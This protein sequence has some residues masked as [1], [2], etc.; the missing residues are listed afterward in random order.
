VV[1]TA[2]HSLLVQKKSVHEAEE[3]LSWRG[4]YLTFD[5]TLLADAVA[6]FNRY[7]PQ[8][9]VIDDPKLAALRISGKFRSTYAE[10]FVQLLKS[11]F[12]VEVRQNNETI[13]LTA[14]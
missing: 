2:R 3:A 6:E 11:G 13:H 9:I 12:G 14:N 10:D 5:K 4:G 8:R 7:T 1:H